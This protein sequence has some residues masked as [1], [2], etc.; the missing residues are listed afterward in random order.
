MTYCA[1][2][3]DNR[4][5]VNLNRTNVCTKTLI[6]VNQLYVVPI[7]EYYQLIFTDISSRKS[8]YQPQFQIK[9][10]GNVLDQKIIYLFV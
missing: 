3:I 8:K 6:Q 2:L 10:R 9:M 5:K 4:S 7:M 1:I